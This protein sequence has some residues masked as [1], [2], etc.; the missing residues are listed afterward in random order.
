MYNI[1]FTLF[2]TSNISYSAF[3]GNWKVL[4]NVK[5]IFY[6]FVELVNYLKSLAFSKSVFPMQ[7]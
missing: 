1:A 6:K 3:F 4:F 2:I 7:H 5:Y